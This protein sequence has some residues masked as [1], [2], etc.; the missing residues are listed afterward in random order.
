MS[1]VYMISYEGQHCLGLTDNTF[2]NINSCV[3]AL[4]GNCDTPKKFL[5]FWIVNLL[6]Y[7]STTNKAKQNKITNIHKLLFS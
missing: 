4:R 3:F 6:W 5:W 1:H 2:H 7:H